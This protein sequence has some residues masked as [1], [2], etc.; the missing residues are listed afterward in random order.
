MGYRFQ[1]PR[2]SDTACTTSNAFSVRGTT[3]SKSP[4]EL[5]GISEFMASRYPRCLPLPVGGKSEHFSTRL[6]WRECQ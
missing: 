4:S 3:T 5:S 6:L 1:D 2:R